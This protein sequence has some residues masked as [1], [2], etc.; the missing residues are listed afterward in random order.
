VDDVHFG[1]V[2]WF[3][4]EKGYG[5][6]VREGDGA[7][8]FVHHTELSEPRESFPDRRRNLIGPGKDRK[9]GERVK[10]E[11]DNTS[12]GLQARNVVRVP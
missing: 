12:R 10:F 11:V 7:E 3:S 8:V 4:A 5:F 6:I 2:K 1:R 9:E